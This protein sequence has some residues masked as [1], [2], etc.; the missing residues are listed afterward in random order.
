VG[1]ISPGLSKIV[2]ATYFGSDAVNCMGSECIGAWGS[3]GFVA[4]AVDTSG[5]IIAS[6]DVYLRVA[7]P[8]PAVGTTTV[9][10]APGGGSV[11][12]STAINPNGDSQEISALALDGSGNVLVVGVAENGAVGTAG[13]VQPCF[14]PNNEIV[15]VIVGGFIGK[16][17]GSSGAVSS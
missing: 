7:P 13:T 9:K 14:G 8:P 6:A 15:S 16:L 3:T 11:V 2:F 1:E 10:F 17:S 5:A 4:L 12:W